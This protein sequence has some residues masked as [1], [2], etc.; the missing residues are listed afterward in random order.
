MFTHIFHN[1]K[2]LFPYQ[3]R[4]IC[5]ARPNSRLVRSQEFQAT[6]TKNFNFHTLLKFFKN[7]TV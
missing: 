3:Q 7:L 1:K 5:G 2:V 6:D 4:N